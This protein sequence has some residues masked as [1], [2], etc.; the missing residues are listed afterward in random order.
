M[1]SS[2]SERPTVSGVRECLTI[3][4]RTIIFV[5]GY[6]ENCT[7]TIVSWEEN[8]RRRSLIFSY[9]VHETYLGSVWLQA[10]AHDV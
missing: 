9:R 1:N 10:V 5:Y 7:I 6:T 4:N 3:A 8:A 2:I